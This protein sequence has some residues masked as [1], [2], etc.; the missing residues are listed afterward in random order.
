MVDRDNI[1]Q[2]IRKLLALANNNPSAAEA[3][4]SA[5]KAQK[6][7]ANYDIAKEEL[8]DTVNE[9]IVE[10]ESVTYKGNAWNWYLAKAIAD[11]F[12]C[13]VYRW[14]HGKGLGYAY[15]FVGYEADA[16]ACSIVFNQLYKL[17][18]K[19]GDAEARKIRK[20]T[21]TAVGVKGTFLI[22]EKGD[23]GFVGGI[24]KE[25]EKQC[26]AL[27]L[28]IPKSVNDYMDETYPTMRHFQI[29][30]STTRD[31]IISEHGFYEGVNAI[32]SA[33]IGEQKKIGA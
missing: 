7:I 19:L 8:Y 22:G 9:E 15:R 24:R 16:E 32:R 6:M 5:L 33:R 18:N 3:T 1:I 12:R 14:G 13:R 20:E 21:G 11:N 25:L 2:K 4:A 27:M 29:R 10:I 30:A 26:Q 31:K 23:G 28:V 17:G